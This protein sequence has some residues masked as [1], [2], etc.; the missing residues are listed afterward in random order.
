[1]LLAQGN[2]M[3]VNIDS[4]RGQNGSTFPCHVCG[5]N[6]RW[7]KNL[8]SHIELE[9][10]KEPQLSCPV[11]ECLFLTK[12]KSSLRRHFDRK[13]RKDNIWDIDPITVSWKYFN[14]FTAFFILILLLLL[15]LKYLSCQYFSII[16]LMKV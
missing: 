10:G 11:P 2:C 12:F 13:H 3:F 8:R 1:M 16:Y 4:W 6:Y 7:E 9:C 15:M 14:I 5:R